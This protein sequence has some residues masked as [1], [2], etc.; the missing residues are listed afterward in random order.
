[1]ELPEG[2]TEVSYYGRIISKNG[3]GETEYRITQGSLPPGLDLSSRGEIAGYPRTA[4]QYKI[5]IEGRDRAGRSDARSFT[6]LI[7]EETWGQAGKDGGKTRAVAA[8]L[9]ADNE[10][11]W[12]YHGQEPVL[13]VLAAGNRIITLSAEGI[14]ALHTANGKVYWVRRGTYKKAAFAGGRLYALSESGLETIDPDIGSL[15]WSRE[16]VTSFSTDGTIILADDGSACLVIDGEQGTLLEKNPR[17]YGE[18]ERVIWRNG[19]AFI[20]GEH[21]IV[22][23]GKTGGTGPEWKSAE[24]IHAAA[25]DG[26]GFA[27]AVDGA[28][29][30]LDRDLLELRRVEHPFSRVNGGPGADGIQ[31][32]L[33]GDG[34]LVSHRG[35][36][37]EY[38]RDD[39]EFRWIQNG[40][41][42]IALGKD[43]A[44]F[45][46]TG[47]MAVLNRYTGNRI[48]EDTGSYSSF[49]LYHERIF[50]ADSHGNIYCYRGSPNKNAPETTIQ[51]SPASPDGKNGWYRTAPSVRILSI[52]RETYVEEIK[53]WLDDEMWE[54]PEIPLVLA[55]GEHS[56]RAYG[57]DSLGIRSRETAAYITVDT[58]LPESEYTLSVPESPE[59]WYREPVTISLEGWDE[60]SGLERIG[61]SLGTYTAPMLF[62]LQGVYHFYWYALDRAGNSEKLRHYEIRIDTE[63]PYADALVLY[64]T[65]LSEVVLSA[66]DTLSGLEGIEYRINGGPPEQYYEPLRF[67]GEGFTR[68]QYRAA[69]KAGNFGDWRDC[70]VWVAPNR[71]GVSLIA[72][73][74]V[75]GRAVS[76][77]Y[78]A[79]NGMPLLGR[80]D[81]PGVKPPESPEPDNRDREKLINLPPYALGGEYLLFEEDVIAE[82]ETQRIRFQVTKN[83]VVYLFIPRSMEAPQGFSFVEE[84]PG[85]NRTYYPG[86]TGVYMKRFNAGGTVELEGSSR[87][88]LP[89]LVLVQERQPVFG[90]IT[91]RIEAGTPP[92]DA[93]VPVSP[94]IPGD[95][96]AGKTVTLEAIVSPWQYSRR[97][98]LRQRWFVNAGAEWM[99]LEE[100]RYTLPEESGGGYVRFR[101]E[102]YTPDGQ[103]EYRTEKTVGIVKNENEEV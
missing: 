89:P 67:T 36:V 19:N 73:P 9:P 100:N 102:L 62:A 82:D 77:L 7:R 63:P 14:T 64:D 58:G 41:G 94:S 32:A 57:V 65:G 66:Q 40:A 68:I 96:E 13:C 34:I 1:L 25:A 15:L 49:A 83:A 81:E 91:V 74:T 38:G 87:G 93:G 60:V 76:V 69:D 16:G 90:E 78:N 50:A 48:W 54:D 86:G 24:R 95:F 5:L 84:R 8:D 85:I 10:V 39:L 80:R 75:G 99:P 43:K 11:A 30:L 101:L 26:N 28:L 103:L 12:T 18:P 55:N 47:G 98:P 3:T 51:L 29:V 61:T 22:L 2:L 52:D 37:S 23:A 44:I 72:H 71:T 97:L 56:I 79:G 59:G 92:D 31:L 88:T 33:A 4:G 35:L 45:A 27:V 46:G 70:E 53:A 21:G 20:A 6:I 17:A 42:D